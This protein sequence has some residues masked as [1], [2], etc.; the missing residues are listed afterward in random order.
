MGLLQNL[1]LNVLPFLSKEDPNAQL[2][3]QTRGN[4]SVVLALSIHLYNRV[5]GPAV[6]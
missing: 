5:P 6:Q 2:P 3:N 4:G 1:Q